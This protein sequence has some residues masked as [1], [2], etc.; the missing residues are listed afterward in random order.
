MSKSRIATIALVEDDPI[1]AELYS[2]WLTTSGFTVN[3]YNSAGDFRRRLGAESV[4][5]IVL[6]W[7]LPDTPGIEL[8][9][10]LKHS[11]HTRIP[12]IF[13]TANQDEADVVAALRAGADDYVSKP[14]RSGELVARVQ[15][16]LR[17][18]TPS[19]SRDPVIEAAPF[20]LEL[21]TRRLF[22]HGELQELTDREFEL[23]AFMFR[24]A[25]RVISRELLLAEVWNLSGDV[26]TRTIDTHISR[27]RKKLGLNGDSGWRVASVCLHGYRLER[28]VGTD[29]VSAESSESVAED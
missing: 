4:D 7:E 8:L 23:L 5:A 3:V 15:A 17:R 22:L 26:T 25:G 10:W 12:V 24:R 6:D 29:G 2:A 27:L 19:V 16:A 11:P 9:D 18:S 13:L 14:A 20:R 21:V 28:V 1:H